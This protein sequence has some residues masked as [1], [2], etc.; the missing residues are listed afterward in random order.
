MGNVAKAPPVSN[1]YKPH[2]NTGETGSFCL[3]LFRQNQNTKAVHINA[4]IR[5]PITGALVYNAKPINGVVSP[6]KL[7]S[8]PTTRS[9]ISWNIINPT[10]HKAIICFLVITQTQIPNSNAQPITGSTSWLTNILVRID[11]NETSRKSEGANFSIPTETKVSI[12]K[13]RNCAASKNSQN[14]VR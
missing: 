14:P 5:M 11:E 6:R 13:S 3:A 4:S 10:H 12:K 8:K 7:C 9:H 1:P 2:I